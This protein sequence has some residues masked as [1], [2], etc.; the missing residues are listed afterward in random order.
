MCFDY[1]LSICNAA[2]CTCRR[3]EGAIGNVT[4]WAC[5][6]KW[7][8]YTVKQATFGRVWSL[9]VPD[10]D[11]GCG[12]MKVFNSLG[13][14]VSFGSGLVCCS[15]E[16][17]MVAFQASYHF[18]SIALRDNSRSNIHADHR[19]PQLVRDCRNNYLLNYEEDRPVA[20]G[21]VPKL[22]LIVSN[23]YFMNTKLLTF[24]R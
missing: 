6:L 20:N 16:S 24:L 3:S 21:F 4:S 11:L 15:F 18:L 17:V 22:N 19:N 2:F 8:G 12:K 10:W 9:G 13:I 7:G 14:Y 1:K 5:T 23:I